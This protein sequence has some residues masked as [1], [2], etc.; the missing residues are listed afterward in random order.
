[1]AVHVPGESVGERGWLAE[2]P[3]HR[4]GLR[5][6]R[7]SPFGVG[8]RVAERSAGESGKEPDTEA[9]VF[10]AERVE[11]ALEQ[12]REI[13]VVSRRAPGEPAAVAEGCPSQ[14]VGQPKCLSEPCGLSVTVL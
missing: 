12:H 11:R 6:E 9:A 5:P 10:L 4:E 14:L 1:M 3:G 2:P 13:L 8:G 7:P